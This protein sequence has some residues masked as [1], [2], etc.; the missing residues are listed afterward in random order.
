MSTATL[1]A[2]PSCDINRV[3]E[4]RRAAEQT[5]TRYIPRKPSL[6]TSAKPAPFDPNGGRAA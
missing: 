1:H 5:G 2:L 4:L 3:F 6:V